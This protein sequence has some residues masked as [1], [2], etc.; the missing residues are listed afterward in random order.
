MSLRIALAAATLSVTGC[1][2]STFIDDVA[3]LKRHTEV[4][5]LVSMTRQGGF[6]GSHYADAWG[7]IYF[8]VKSGKK[9]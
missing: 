6:N 4:K 7:L 9:G 8:L 1:T 5:K 2:S 3:F